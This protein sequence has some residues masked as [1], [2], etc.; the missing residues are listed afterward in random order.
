MSG[1]SLNRVNE[2][3]LALSLSL[4]ISISYISEKDQTAL[5]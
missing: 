5:G 3:A 1:P 4:N 2:D